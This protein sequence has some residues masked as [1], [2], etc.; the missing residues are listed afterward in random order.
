VDEA[1]QTAPACWHRQGRAALEEEEDRAAP[2]VLIETATPPHLCC[3]SM[4][5]RMEP[6]A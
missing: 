1:G 4:R 2:T 3:S 6:R 5:F